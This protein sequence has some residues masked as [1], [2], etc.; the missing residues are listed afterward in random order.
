MAGAQ[1]RQ[2]RRD[3]WY[4]RRSRYREERK[5]RY[6]N[7]DRLRRQKG[8][9]ESEEPLLEEPLLEEPLAES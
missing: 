7:S 2:Q 9:S 5:Y 3:H 6:Q 1:R 8:G 4:K